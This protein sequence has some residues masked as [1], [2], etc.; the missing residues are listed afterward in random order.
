M[1]FGV[2]RVSVTTDGSDIGCTL[3]CRKGPSYTCKLTHLVR[4]FDRV[5]F[6][7]FGGDAVQIY[8]YG[9]ATCNNTI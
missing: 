2:V 3:N 7:E 6:Q 4:T 9:H 5:L 1:A 8:H